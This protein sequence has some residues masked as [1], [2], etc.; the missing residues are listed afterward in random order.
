MW[1][2]DLADGKWRWMGGS[3]MQGASPVYPQLA[4]SVG[5]PGARYGSAT[6]TDDNGNFWMF[7]GYGP[8]V[9]S[10][11][12]PVTATMNDM[13]KYDP[14]TS[15]WTYEG[16]PKVLLD[17]GNYPPAHNQSGYPA[18]RQ[19]AASGKTP[20]GDFL[21][22]G[23]TSS[24]NYLND[25]WRF[26]PSSRTWTWIGGSAVHSAN[27]T[28]PAAAGGVGYPGARTTM[29]YWTDS[30]SDFWIFGGFGMPSSGGV[31]RLNDLW[32]YQ[33]QNNTFFYMSGATVFSQATQYPAS[34]GDVGVLGG[35]NI[36]CFWSGGGKFWLSGGYG[37][38]SG[39]AEGRFNDLWA[40][41]PMEGNWRFMD[42]PKGETAGVYPPALEMKGLPAGRMGGQTWTVG[43]RMFLYGGTPDGANPLSDMWYH[44]TAPNS[45]VADWMLLE[46]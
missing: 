6:W 26:T 32:R 18:H 22:F 8:G 30:N 29:A 17:Q 42:G 43:N 45:S 5:Q 41:D 21:L 36:A 20:A 11:G 38:E 46:Q 12:N 34:H 7:G 13:W 19:H 9:S 3:R 2:Y 23:G 39:G 16:G 28:Y 27:G 35:R 24:S 10:T 40:H 1:K 15:I 4:G 33:A 37:R 44:Y 14:V 25:L 31:N